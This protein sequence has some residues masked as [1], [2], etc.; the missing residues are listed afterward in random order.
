MNFGK[1]NCRGNCL[2]NVLDRENQANAQTTTDIA[3]ETQCCSNERPAATQ[4]FKKANGQKTDQ[5]FK[6]DL[7]REWVRP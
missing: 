5:L 2:Q 4:F 6:I 7:A 3:F 1:K